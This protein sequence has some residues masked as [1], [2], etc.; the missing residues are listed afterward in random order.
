MSLDWWTLGLQTINVVVLVWLL[1]RFL[2]KPV[3]RI[4]AE[5]QQAAE[6]LLAEADQARQAA[7]ETRTRIEA[8]HQALQAQR[9]AALAQVEQDVQQAR[10]QL[11]QAA[12]AEA[13][14]H[15]RLAEAQWQT[16][17]AQM[18]QTLEAQAAQ[19]AL[20]IAA[21][22]LQRLP[23]SARVIGFID[24]LAEATAR[25]PEAVRQGLAEQ[26]DALVLHAPRALDEAELAACL[27][28]LSGVLARQPTL[29]VRVDPSLIAGL[30]LQ[31]RT[32]QVHNSLRADLARVQQE[33][34]HGAG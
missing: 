14:E 8:E 5:R 17:Q 24:G 9:D 26:S 31:G 20:E 2:F 33:L 28:A 27:D 3:A 32:A 1:S 11:L 18:R 22:L 30:E 7:D 4:I 16:Q 13:D 21:R 10:E 19:L 12:R 34:Q 15:R 29:E 25:L 6:R 23:E